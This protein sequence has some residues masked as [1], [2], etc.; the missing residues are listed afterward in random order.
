[1][2]RVFMALALLAMLGAGL[3]A[4]KKSPPPEVPAAKQPVMGEMHTAVGVVKEIGE[5]KKTVTFQHE[6][7]KDGFM[8][9]MTMSFEIRDPK[10][11]D[12][13]KLEDKAEF[14][15]KY[16]GDGFPIVVLKKLPK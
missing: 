2:K 13:L 6:A 4:C 5:N 12:G 15:I 10:L 1:M 3:A 8:E 7:F 14:T 9:G 11:L 16:T